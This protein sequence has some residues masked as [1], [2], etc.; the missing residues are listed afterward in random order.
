MAAEREFLRAQGGGC[1]SPVAAYAKIIGHRLQM[2]AVSFRI[3]PPR[4]ITVEGKL[5]EA[6]QLGRE[7]ARQLEKS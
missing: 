3:T 4:W 1:Q 7:A 2:R 5:T 6:E